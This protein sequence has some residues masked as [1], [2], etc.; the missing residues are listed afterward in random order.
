MKDTFNLTMT[1][2]RLRRQRCLKAIVLALQLCIIVAVPPGISAL[3]PWQ[4]YYDQGEQALSQEK[5]ALAEEYL[6][7]AL[8]LAESS[9]P[10]SE[11]TQKC[12]QKLADTLTLRDKTDEAERLYRRLLNILVKQYGETKPIVPV[13]M[14]LGSIQES[15]GDHSA[16]TVYYQRALRINEKGFGPYSPEFVN[17]IH[18]LARSNARAGHKAQAAKQY[19]QAIDILMQE[20]S[21]KASQQLEDVMH[22]YKDLLQGSENSDKSLINEFKK[23]ILN[24]WPS[25]TSRG[26]HVHTSTSAPADQNS[27]AGAGAT[28]TSPTPQIGTTAIGLPQQEQVPQLR[29]PITTSGTDGIGGTMP[30]PDRVYTPPAYHEGD[31]PPATDNQSDWQ[32]SMASR[33]NATMQSQLNQDPDVVLRGM[34]Q[35]WSSQSF[36]PAYK[37]Q[38]E[39]ILNQ[40]RYGKGED[41]YQRAIATDISAL[42]PHHPSVANDLNGLAQ[43]YIH[44]QDYA[45]A[46]PLLRDADAIYQ[47]T[48]GL[49]NP[50][51]LNVLTSYALVESHLGKPDKAQS[52][53]QTALSHSQSTLGPN[54]MLTARILN[55]LA[56]LFYHQGQL[57]KAGTYYKWALAS[58]EAAAGKESPLLAASLH[59]YARVLRSLGQTSE[60]ETLE[61]RAATISTSTK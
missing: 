59:D 46:E 11:A 50:L 21:L 54:S 12:L 61:T 10:T 43:L 9:G 57:D 19:K 25:K 8:N 20:P 38:T 29:P 27:S 14:S 49:D 30:Q 15:L 35:P 56:Y 28:N 6:R 55:E 4:S 2:G 23:D 44:N 33:L 22:D 26:K 42:G 39:S 51:S 31:S 17:N 53:Y 41:Y 13:L 18:N 47:Q 16:A 36:L 34:S 60:A 24:P 48:Y 52:L 5:P 45:K 32:K 40:S 1:G 37:T 7:K 3:Q 58:T